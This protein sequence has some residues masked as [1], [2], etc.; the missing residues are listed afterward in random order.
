MP[1]KGGRAPTS[2]SRGAQPRVCYWPASGQ[3]LPQRRRDACQYVHTGLSPARVDLSLR[4]ERSNQANAQRLLAP[5]CF[6]VAKPPPRN[7]RIRGRPAGWWGVYFVP[8]L[9]NFCLMVF[10]KFDSIDFGKYEGAPLWAIYVGAPN[11]IEWCIN[12]VE[13]FA[14]ESLA[15]LC[16]NKSLGPD[17][18]F[19]PSSGASWD[20][21][22]KMD[23]AKFLQ[24]AG[25]EAAGFDIKHKELQPLFLARK[26]YE[27][28]LNGMSPS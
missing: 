16:Q 8:I 14:I 15:D 17:P 1:G 11:Y 22:H 27:W 12:E 3:P 20:S 6:V 26:G 13:G 7:D 2:F 4:A 21:S 23:E 19:Y 28:F 25:D 24:M 18:T 9:Q 5:D 10:R